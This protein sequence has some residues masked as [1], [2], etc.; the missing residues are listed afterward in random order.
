MATLTNIRKHGTLLII[1]V[2]LAMLAFILGDFLN[3]GSSFFNRNRE[4]IA[5]IEGQKVHYTEYEEAVKNL[6]EVYKIETGRSNFDEEQTAQ[7][8]N[9]VWQMLLMDYTLRA[10]GERIGMAVNS[11]ELS[12]LCIGAHPHQ[13]IQQRRAF[14]DETGAFNRDNLVRFLASLEQEADNAE[15]QA[16]LEQAKKYWLYWENAVRLTQMQEKYTNLVRSL[17]RANSV[18]AEFAFNGRQESVSADYVMQP[19]YAVADS[20]VKVS[21]GDIK[22]L[23]KLH[24]P[25]YKQTPNRTIEYVTFAI[26]PSQNDYEATKKSMEALY[27]EFKTAE[28][29]AVVVNPNS[30]IIYNGQ[31]YSAETIPAQFKDFA[32]HKGAKAGDVTEIEFLNDTYAC[33]RIMECGYSMPDSVELKA[34]ASQEGQEDQE[35][36]WYQA[37]ELRQDIAEPAFK[38]KRGTR[39][40]V[41]GQEFEIMEISPATPK[42]KVAILAQ[43]VTPSSKTYSVLYNQ[44][45]QFIVTNNTAEAMRDAAKE[46]GMAVTPQYNL[47]KNTEKVGSLTSSRA[48]VRWA[49]EANEG[50]VSDVFECGDLFVVAALTE[51]NDGDYRSLEAVRPELLVEATNNKKA[52]YLQQELSQYTSL[53]EAAKALNKSVQHADAI[54]LS[55]YRFGNGGQEPAIIG[56]ALAAEQGA[57]SAPLKGNNGVYLLVT[58][59]KQ[60]AEGEINVAQEKQQLNA[61][62][63]YQIPY[64]AIALLEEEAKVEDNRANFQ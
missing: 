54:S 18:D 13:L 16:N 4:N 17:I 27:E 47:N 58:S 30:D 7:I 15:Q 1:I 26:R 49:F 32:F 60:V 21:N 11:D 41:N 5:E 50:Q 20:L 38:G 63:S 29:V 31:D 40:T 9:Q 59:N 28:D 24:K 23:Y 19:Y 3:S 2:G 45:K 6:T 8:R 22:K 10:E 34:I 14:Y 44:A 61:R 56:A 12:E 53:E 62:Y 46:A 55:S 57:L 39:F 52:E 37:A 42:A 35:L 33:A 51:V 64:Q 36:G 48:I 25:Q 43:Q